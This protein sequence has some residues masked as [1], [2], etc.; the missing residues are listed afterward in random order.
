[1]RGGKLEGVA[2]WRWL[3]GG[4]EVSLTVELR[5]GPLVE[6]R[7]CGVAGGRWSR[8]NAGLVAERAGK[9]GNLWDAPSNEEQSLSCVALL[10]QVSCRR[11]VGSGAPL[12][13]DDFG[14]YIN[15]V[16]ISTVVYDA[17]P[18]RTRGWHA[19]SR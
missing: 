3:S 12:E 16:F 2:G 5:R 18:D 19:L 14:K 4:K 17:S 10:R 6:I 1:M 11:A 15:Y 7:G 8:V 13:H 9:R